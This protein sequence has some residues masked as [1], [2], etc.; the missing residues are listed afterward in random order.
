MDPTQ[1][2]F[3]AQQRMAQQQN[4]ANLLLN[5]TPDDSDKQFIIQQ[6]QRQEELFIAEATAAETETNQLLT[7]A[8][9][10]EAKAAAEYAQAEAEYQQALQELADAE[11]EVNIPFDEAA[12]TTT[13]LSAAEAEQEAAYQ[14]ELAA[15]YERRALELKRANDLQEL[16]LIPADATNDEKLGYLQQ[17]ETKETAKKTE[18][19]TLFTTYP[20]KLQGELLKA[21]AALQAHKEFMHK[22]AEQINIARYGFETSNYHWELR[23]TGTRY[24]MDYK[25]KT[26]KTFRV[27]NKI[28]PPSVKPTDTIMYRWDPVKLVYN[29]T[30]DDG[31]TDDDR[32]RFAM[33]GRFDPN[34]TPSGGLPVRGPAVKLKFPEL[35][36][37]LQGRLN[38]R[39]AY[40]PCKPG[41]W[42]YERAPSE[43]SP[44]VYMGANMLDTKPS[45]YP[46]S[47][48]AEITVDPTEVNN[49]FYSQCSKLWTY[50]W[51][52]TRNFQECSNRSIFR[53]QY[54]KTCP[55]GTTELITLTDKD[56][57]SDPQFKRLACAHM[58]RHKDGRFTENDL[59]TNE[60]AQ[61]AFGRWKY[62]CD[63][64]AGIIPNKTPEAA[65]EDCMATK[66]KG[67]GFGALIAYG[68]A[69]EQC[70]KELGIYFL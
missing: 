39:R 11:D 63:Q 34:K 36:N 2:A 22:Y 37:K 35:G 4:D 24:V 6:N 43:S 1:A 54:F 57:D 50:C 17:I 45:Y 15:Y 16:G 67:S 9:D 52:Q 60:T 5:R 59:L 10:E 68:N 65:L 25:N 18:T 20:P 12:Y 21:K 8:V 42:F 40:E 55:D 69:K 32:L 62:E 61:N 31:V 48:E 28:E 41:Y 14:A 38:D 49:D 23:Q 47:V 19:D 66:P 13:E 64:E 46:A 33:D 7:E 26:V 70:R 53:G 44:C 3:L 29:E 58:K 56:T 27:H 30:P 51:G